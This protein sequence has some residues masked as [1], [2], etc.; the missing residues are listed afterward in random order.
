M[1][2]CLPRMALKKSFIP[3]LNYMSS[4]FIFLRVEKAA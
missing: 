2:I 1:Q 4:H 3:D